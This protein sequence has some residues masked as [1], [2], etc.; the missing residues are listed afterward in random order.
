MANRTHMD[1]YTPSGTLNEINLN[2]QNDLLSILNSAFS[3]T[4]SVILANKM[5]KYYYST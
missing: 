4:I 1:R 2:N 5:L 3:I